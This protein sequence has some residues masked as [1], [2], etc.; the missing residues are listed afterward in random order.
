MSNLAD[1]LKLKE[2]STIVEKGKLYF[3]ALEEKDRRASAI[4]LACFIALIAYFGIWSPI[5]EYE[6]SA[7]AERDRQLELIQWMKSTEKRARSSEKQNVASLSGQS[8][9]TQISKTAKIYK[10]TPSRLQ[11]EGS[12]GVSVWFDSVAFNSLIKW[13]Q[14]LHLDGNIRVKQISIDEQPESGKVSARMEFS[15]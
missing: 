10:I 4:L 9:L 13:L 7:K 3:L 8:L 1:T 12:N 11:P 15:S 14:K 5:N 2:L 6:S